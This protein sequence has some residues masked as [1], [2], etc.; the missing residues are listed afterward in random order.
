MSGNGSADRNVQFLELMNDIR[1]GAMYGAPRGHIEVSPDMLAAGLDAAF[2]AELYPG[3]D[4]FGDH[5]I[6]R[7][8]V[9]MERVRIGTSAD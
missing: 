3:D 7:I 8:Y 4:P 1:D 5:V 9:A 2:S 6:Y